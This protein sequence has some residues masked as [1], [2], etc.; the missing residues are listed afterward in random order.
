MIISNVTIR[1][2]EPFVFYL[3]GLIRPSRAAETETGFFFFCRYSTLYSYGGSI[4]E[5]GWSDPDWENL[6]SLT[7]K[8][9]SRE[10]RVSTMATPTSYLTHASFIPSFSITPLTF[11]FNPYFS[12]S[13]S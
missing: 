12:T 8:L 2:K 13:L 5:G 3:P 9:R 7:A 4:L 11:T 10:P 1:L 6:I